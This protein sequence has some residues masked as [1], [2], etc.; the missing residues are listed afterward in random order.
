MQEP[1]TQFQQFYNAFGASPGG[2]TS[3]RIAYLS[4]TNAEKYC[5][6]ADGWEA[7]VERLNSGE[8]IAAD[9]VRVVDDDEYE[10]IRKLTRRPL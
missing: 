1:K 5:R 9:K 6:N 7:V 10:R 2:L 8:I 3:N 4:R